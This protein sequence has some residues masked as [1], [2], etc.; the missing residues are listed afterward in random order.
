MEKIYKYIATDENGETIS[1][2]ESKEE[3][4]RDIEEY[5]RIKGRYNVNLYKT[6]TN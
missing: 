2:S 3:I 4:L 6:S 5:A 1:S